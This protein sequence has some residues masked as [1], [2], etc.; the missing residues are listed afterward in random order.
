M[1]KLLVKVAG[2]FIAVLPIV[3]AMAM[4]VSANSVATPV[5]R[6]PIP[7]QSIKKYR[8]F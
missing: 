2:M 5:W 6:Q 4:T 1:K 7:P 8:K 3:A